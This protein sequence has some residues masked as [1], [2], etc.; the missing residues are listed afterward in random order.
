MQKNKTAEMIVAGALIGG[1]V[2]YL[3]YTERGS[4]WREQIG[5]IA[6]N[7]I[8]EWLASLEEKLAEAEANAREKEKEVVI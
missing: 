5:D 8:D 1:V 6:A 3:F 4:R 2:Y 7:T